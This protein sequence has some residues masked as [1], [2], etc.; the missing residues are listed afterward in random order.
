[1]DTTIKTEKNLT[2]FESIFHK[3]KDLAK[4][5][6]R[7]PFLAQRHKEKVSLQTGSNM[8]IKSAA[9]KH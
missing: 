2:T 4:V 9:I 7:K 1:M 8:S 3:L 6:P 5:I